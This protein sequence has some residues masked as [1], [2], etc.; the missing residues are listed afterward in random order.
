MFP[1]LGRSPGRAS[2][3][4]PRSSSFALGQEQGRGSP[5]R[6]TKPVGSRC[7]SSTADSHAVDGGISA[8]GVAEN[9]QQLVVFLRQ[10]Y[11]F[12]NDMLV[13]SITR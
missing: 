5:D 3:S 12:N 2:P 8:G 10:S 6:K 11:R 13:A 7:S 4:R 9:S 1:A